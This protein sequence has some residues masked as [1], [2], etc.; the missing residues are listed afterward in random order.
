M[1]PAVGPQGECA[2]WRINI[3]TRDHSTSAA[4]EYGRRQ[5]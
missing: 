5:H 4:L 2:D 1:R 3:N